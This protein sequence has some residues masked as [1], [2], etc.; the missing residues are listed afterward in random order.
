MKKIA[1]ILAGLFVGLL[2]TQAQVAR[3]STV[4]P[5][6]TTWLRVNE[7]SLTVNL[8]ATEA[9]EAIGVES[10]LAYTGT[11]DQGWCSVTC[12]KEGQAVIAAEKNTGAELRTATVNLSAKDNHQVSIA[13]SQLGTEPCILVKEK[14][15]KAN[16]C[17]AGIHPGRDGQRRG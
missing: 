7:E 16:Q 17:P 11:S 5:E 9:T 2:A 10:N 13:V 14:R 3:V 8:P 12:G 6:G 4:A 15:D 1:S